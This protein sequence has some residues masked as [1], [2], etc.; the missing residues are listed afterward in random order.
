MFAGSRIESHPSEEVNTIIYL[1][2]SYSSCNEYIGEKS[3]YIIVSLNKW[4]KSYDNYV[5]KAGKGGTVTGTGTAG[6]VYI[7]PDAGNYGAIGADTYY[8]QNA[9]ITADTTVT[10]AK[11]FSINSIS[12]PADTENGIST[13]VNVTAENFSNEEAPYMV[14]AVY[15]GG[16][17]VSCD[18]QD[19]PQSSSNKEFNIDCKLEA[20]KTYIVKAMLWNKTQKPLTSAY[21]ITVNK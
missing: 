12:T 7:A 21:Q 16:K 10:F 14:V 2:D 6:E 18:V 1:N 9:P 4:L 19:T 11:E 20:G 13:N 17:L 5:V 15:E 8:N 3:T